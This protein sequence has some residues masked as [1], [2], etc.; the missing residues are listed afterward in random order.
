M[1]HTFHAAHAGHPFSDCGVHREEDKLCHQR[2]AWQL[3]PAITAA[4]RSWL[5]SDPLQGYHH[6]C[7]YPTSHA[8]VPFMYPLCASLPGIVILFGTPARVQ[9][10]LR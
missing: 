4:N 5:A 1:G 6:P 7:E 3:N 2:Q 8:H 10:W 9:D